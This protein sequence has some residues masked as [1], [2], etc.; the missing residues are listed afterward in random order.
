MRQADG[1]EVFTY[2]SPGCRHLYEVEPKTLLNDFGQVWAIIYPDDRNRVN[3]VNHQSA[4]RLER[5]NIEFRLCTPSGGVR[6][7]R[8]ISQ[9]ERQANGDVVWDGFVV[10]IS[11]RIQLEAERKLAETELRQSEQLLRLALTG[12]QAGSWVWDVPTGHLSWS[13]ETYYL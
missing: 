4:Q 2:V 1:T 11:D 8:A 6:W 9:P 10:D 7:V 5:F 13:L 3:Q 12:A